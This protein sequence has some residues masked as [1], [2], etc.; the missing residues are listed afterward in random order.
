MVWPLALTALLWLRRRW[1]WAL[2]V[3]IVVLMFG[4]AMCMVYETA[5][6]SQQYVTRVPRPDAAPRG[7]GRRRDARPGREGPRH[8][9]DHG[10]APGDRDRRTR[11]TRGG[12]RRVLSGQLLQPLQPA[13][14][15]RLSGVRVRG[16][17][18]GRGRI[19]AR[20]AGARPR[21]LAGADARRSAG[22]PTASTCTTC[23]SFFGSPRRAPA[24]T[25]RRCSHCGSRS[26]RPSWSC[27]TSSSN[28]QY[29]SRRVPRR[30]LA[31]AACGHRRSCSA[32]P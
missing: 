11:C 15:R 29:V 22:S 18:L 10:C 12:D 5:Y 7:A 3:G 25:A 6:N 9:D 32:S 24:S 4:S 27:R 8:S 14:A 13:R 17:W 20:V 21:A 30:A 31:F 16:R 23:R 1:R 19:A 28:G 2:H 26:R